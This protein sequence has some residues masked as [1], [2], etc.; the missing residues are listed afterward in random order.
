MKIKKA[1]NLGFCFGVR[2]A[3]QLVEQAAAEHGP[4]DSLGSVVHNP[5]VVERLAAKNVQVIDGVEQAG[6]GTVAITAHGA[7][8]QIADEAAARG[9]R[10]VDATCP[11]VRKSQ[12]VAQRLQ[13]AGFQV[14]IYGDQAHPEV[15]AVLAWTNGHGCAL[16]DPE[17][18]LATRRRKVALPSPRPP[19]ARRPSRPSWPG[20]S[21]STLTA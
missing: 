10:L 1:K 21:L 11:I 2:R 19:E 14:I 15:R 6:N 5:Q 7:G 18:P 17:A 4:I 16:E 12:K 13:E 20:S 9:L 3:I 8:P